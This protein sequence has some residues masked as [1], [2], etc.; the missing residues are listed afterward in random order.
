MF[1]SEGETENSDTHIAGSSLRAFASYMAFS[2]R[3]VKVLNMKKLRGM[4]GERTT[5]SAFKPKM[6]DGKLPL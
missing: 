4:R 1:Q 3:R 2:N 6:A 5:M